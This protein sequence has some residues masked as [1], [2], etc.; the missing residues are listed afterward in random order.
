MEFFYD[1]FESVYEPLF[2]ELEENFNKNSFGKSF[3][4][5]FEKSSFAPL[6]FCLIGRSQ[7]YVK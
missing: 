7:D 1:P 3:L 6:I 4:F 2:V 5:R